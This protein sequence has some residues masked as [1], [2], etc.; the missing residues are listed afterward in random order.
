MA[1]DL[2]P[3]IFACT[4]LNG[5]ANIYS[6]DFTTAIYNQVLAQTPQTAADLVESGIA[7]S[8]L[9]NPRGAIA[10]FNQA[11]QIETKI[12][13]SSINRYSQVYALEQKV[14]APN[15]ESLKIEDKPK[16]NT[17]TYAYQKINQTT[18]LVTALSTQNN[19]KTYIGGITV[20]RD[21]TMTQAI[22]PFPP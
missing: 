17:Y 4:N 16:N 12:Y 22:T 15:L 9:K 7:K 11:R 3:I 21:G 19:L 13:V 2:L 5:E 20:S 1:F 10:D 6:Q 18:T 14:V 8:Q